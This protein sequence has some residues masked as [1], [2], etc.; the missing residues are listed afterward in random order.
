MDIQ[1]IKTSF[2]VMESPAGE[3]SRISPQHVM[4]NIRVGD[5]VD[6]P[7]NISEPEKYPIEL[8]YLMDVSYSM[9]EDMKTMK[10]IGEMMADKLKNLTGADADSLVR[11]GFGTFVDKV[12]SPQTEM[13]PYRLQIPYDDA[14]GIRQPFVYRNVNP[15]TENIDDYNNN[16]R[17]EH[18]SGNLDGP[19]G[20]LEAIYHALN[21][22]NEIGWQ[23]NTLKLLVLATESWFHFG[24]NGMG[25]L[26]GLLEPAPQ[27]GECMLEDNEVS[28]SDVYDYPTVAQI[29]TK[30]QENSVIPIFA[31]RKEQLARYN[32]ATEQLFRG[33]T[34]QALEANSSNILDI[35]EESYK[36]IT[37]KQHLLLKQS[38]EI[39]SNVV[40]LG[41]EARFTDSDGNTKGAG[42]SRITKLFVFERDFFQSERKSF[43]VM[44]LKS[45]SAR[46]GCDRFEFKVDGFIHS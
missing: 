34:A 2:D 26:A 42:L 23:E 14:D 12:T 7:F 31:V 15:L 1:T 19:E 9:R 29:V 30:L 43:C 44:T 35:I 40:C 4:A 36:R 41:T 32:E 11:I 33:G 3:P 5:F 24:G 8:Y 20:A 18:V 27:Q 28:R 38:E 6:V 17:D 22:G 46:R 10:S 21:C 16:I 37:Q 13:L 45:L 25:K 39:D